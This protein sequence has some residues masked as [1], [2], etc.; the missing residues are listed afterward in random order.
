M[1]TKKVQ[2]SFIEAAHR[3]P[4]FIERVKSMTAIKH[5]SGN[6]TV[7]TPD[8][9]MKIEIILDEPLFRV[10]FQGDTGDVFQLAH[11]L[12]HYAIYHESK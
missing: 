4:T 3:F 6:V 11:Y 1:S 10:I 8:D 2:F 7:S 12:I 5:S 9:S